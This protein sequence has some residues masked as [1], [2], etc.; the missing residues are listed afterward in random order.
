MSDIIHAPAPM[1]AFDKVWVKLSE[2]GVCDDLGG[3]EYR[4]VKG[5]YHLSAFIE[6]FI[7]KQANLGFSEEGEN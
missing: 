2:E 6:I 5:E 7:R 1:D 4:R 3:A